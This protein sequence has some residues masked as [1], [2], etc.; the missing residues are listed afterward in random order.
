MQTRNPFIDD[1]GKLATGALGAM[2]GLK[3]EVEVLVRSRVER[4]VAD[5]DLVPRE[6]FEAMREAALGARA[7]AESLGV[8]LAALE[9][10]LA[11]LEAGRPKAKRARSDS[12]AGEG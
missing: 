10:R 1:L 2:Q 3:Q 7:E 12:E 8:R 6:E 9:A 4:L 5:L 11:E